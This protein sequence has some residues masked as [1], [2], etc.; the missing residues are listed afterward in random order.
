[1]NL[2]VNARDAMPDG[3]K[4]KI[5]TANTQSYW[6]SVHPRAGGAGAGGAGQAGGGP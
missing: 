3:G 6:S 5:Q 2:V 4:L 1:M